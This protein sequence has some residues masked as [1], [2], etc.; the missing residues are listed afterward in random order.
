M[1]DTSQA[2]QNK[3]AWLELPQE[4]QGA[5]TKTLAERYFHLSKIKEAGEM[6][7]GRHHTHGTWVPGF[8]DRASV[9]PDPAVR[10]VLDAGLKAIVREMAAIS[11]AL[12][13]RPDGIMALL[14]GAV[15]EARSVE[16]G[17]PQPR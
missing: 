17:T 13:Q 10:E 16:V 12:N 4:L 11:Y 14:T 6:R 3:P 5:S 9:E 15:D 2:Q 8:N 7:A 1:N